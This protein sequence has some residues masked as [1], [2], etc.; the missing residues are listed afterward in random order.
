MKRIKPRIAAICMLTFCF[1]L[2]GCTVGDII[3][4][5]TP[6]IDKELTAEELYEKV[7]PSVVEITGESASAISTGTGFF[8]DDKGTVIT[9]Y[10]VIEKCTTAFITL[11]N[12]KSYD[13]VQVLGYSE[14]KD[15][16]ILSTSCNNS[17]PL[18]IRSSAVK[19]G[20]KVY[21]I[22]SSL[23]LSGS[24]SDGIVS[25]AEREVEGHIYIQTT[26]PISHGN[27]GGPLLDSKGYVVGITTASFTDGQNLNL[28]IPIAEIDTISTQNPTTL[29]KIFPQ[30]VEW[31]SER[32]FF[33]YE[34][35]DQYV[36]VFELSDQDQ[37][38]MSSSGTVEI[39]IVN[40]DGTTVY[41]KT[42]TFTE[43]NFEEWTYDGVIDKYLTS[44]Y[45][46]P[47]D[48]T[49]S[50][51]SEGKIYFV[52]YGDDYYFDESTL[53]VKDLPTKPIQVA[54]ENLPKKVNYLSYSGSVYTTTRIDSIT[55]EIK[56]DDCLYIYFAGEKT[57]DHDG[58]NATNACYFSWKLY[59]SEGYLIDSGTISVYGLTV[60][61]KFRGEEGIAFDCIEPGVSYKI[62]ITDY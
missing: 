27:S 29:E 16:A 28:A 32:D 53:D 15:I 58:N 40:N 7:S 25:S 47:D 19:T 33:Y 9:N 59:D 12:G 61:D 56:Y 49:P 5:I 26:A 37:V 11:S 44:I 14:S 8:Y 45:I 6:N 10:H 41:Q 3:D 55:Y 35:N 24:L 4:N 23:G 30:T 60:G 39:R 48:I 57:Y 21:A 52:V 2:Q 42:R 46:N 22:G 34:D 36:L 38:P 43:S 62:V 1:M 31:I 51:S 50:T 54:T 13:V 18:K 20:E 17:V